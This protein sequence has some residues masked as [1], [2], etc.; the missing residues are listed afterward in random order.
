MNVDVILKCYRGICCPENGNTGGAGLLPTDKF[1]HEIFYI[2][3]D[4]I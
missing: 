1:K 3:M 4:R 2:Q